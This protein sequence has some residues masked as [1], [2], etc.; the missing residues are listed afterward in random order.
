MIDGTRK[1]TVGILQPSYLPWLGFFEQ[2]NRCDIFVYYDDVQFEKGS[3]RNRNRIKTPEGPQWLTVPVTIKGQGF[4]S[5]KDVRINKVVPWAKKHVRAI[6]QNYS[7]APFFDAYAASLFSL[8]ERDWEF[9]IDL[10]LAILDW[11]I[12]QLGIQTKTVLSSELGIPG[13]RVER[14]VGIIKRCGGDVFYE[15]QAGRSYIDVEEFE[16]EGIT[17][18]FQ[19]Y[20]HP[21]YPQLHGGFVSHLSVIDL[22]LNCGPESLGIIGGEHE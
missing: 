20:R 14:L 7:K 10:N 13:A 11:M 2:M 12:D 18:M 6:I 21:E 16:K 8:L 15:G 3:W 22:I 17:V 19:D 5:I 9:L 1:R 4:P